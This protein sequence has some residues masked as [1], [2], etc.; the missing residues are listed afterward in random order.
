MILSTPRTESIL[1][2]TLNDGRGSGFALAVLQGKAQE[3]SYLGY[4]YSDQG[5]SL[6]HP[7]PG[8]DPA[9]VGPQSIFD[10]A[11]LTKILVTTPLL[12]QAKNAGQLDWSDKLESY[13]TEFAGSNITIAQLMASKAGFLAHEKYYERSAS[14]NFPISTAEVLQRI[15]ESPRQ[16]LEEATTVYADLSALL[17]GF[18]LEKIHGKPINQLFVEEIAKPLSLRRSGYRVLPHA[19]EAAQAYSLQ[20][21]L[22]DFVATANCPIH[23][24]LVIGEVDDHNC[25]G[26]GGY[27]AHA[28]LFSSLE[29]TMLLLR[30]AVDLAK[31]DKEYFFPTKES[32]PPFTHGFMIYPGLRPID[33]HVWELGFGHTGFVGTSAWY[34]P[35]TETYMVLLGNARVHPNREDASFVDTRLTAH[36]VL[37]QEMHSAP[38]PENVL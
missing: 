22:V 33:E 19:P 31:T 12:I 21:E 18:I 10:L 1:E 6:D 32:A 36:S 14:G 38:D 16:K 15:A 28:G 8:T 23:Q 24:K 13:F 37:Y 27:S 9:P 17:L 35:E 26:L 34:H 3:F 2:E 5:D 7:L 20:A 25:W 29:E 11:S 4:H 30:H